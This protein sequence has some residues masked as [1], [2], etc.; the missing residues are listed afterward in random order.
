MEEFLELYFERANQMFQGTDYA[1]NSYS[2]RKMPA[3]TMDRR[4]GE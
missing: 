2:K 4:L 1:G 3:Y